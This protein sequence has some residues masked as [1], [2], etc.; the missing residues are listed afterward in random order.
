MKVSIAILNW[1]G[2][3]LLKRFLPSVIEHSTGADIYVIDNASTDDSIDYIGAN[4]PSVKI[5]KLDHNYG[6]ARGYNEGLK[7]IDADIFC[8]L[9]NDVEVTQNWLGPII[10]KFK[11]NLDIAVIQPKILDL[12]R[13]SHFEYA[14]A[15]GGFID[16]FGYPYCR[17]RIFNSLEVDHGQYNHTHEIFWA[18]GA[19]FFVRSYIFQEFNGFDEDFFAHMEEIDFC[20]RLNNNN[21]KVYYEGEAAVYHLGGGTLK[22]INPKKT[23][24][25]FRNSLYA[26]TKNASGNVFFLVLI[27][28]ILDGLAALR[29]LFK[30]QPLHI[31]AIIHAHLVFYSKIPHLLRQRKHNFEKRKYF[32]I[33]SVVWKYFVL[34]YKTYQDLQ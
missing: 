21:H 12:N 27:R 3:S 7:Q 1:N 34:K 9:N 18:S 6:Y 29:F 16:K 17:G 15:A 22:N 8:L 10:S 4:F 5:V 24:L 33:N 31:V 19:C 20:W 26:L 2:T 28:L 14:G 32:K 13:K 25:N 11:A 30:L 23:Y